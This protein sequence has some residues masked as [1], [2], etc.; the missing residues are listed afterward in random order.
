MSTDNETRHVDIPIANSTV[1]PDYSLKQHINDVAILHLEQDVEF[2]NA[3]LPVCLP[4]AEQ[5]KSNFDNVTAFFA[6]WGSMP[7][8]NNL[9][10]V[11]HE[12][13]LT[14]LSNR[15][16]YQKLGITFVSEETFNVT[17]L[18]TGD[19]ERGSIPCKGLSI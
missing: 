11:L 14:V 15:I 2:T 7:G 5:V 10:A 12:A 17:N 1:H 13:T 4:T 16:C 9:T 3:I 6:G 18:C 19:L 8:Q